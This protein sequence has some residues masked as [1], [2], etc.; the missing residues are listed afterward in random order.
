LVEAAEKK[1][2]AGREK[3]NRGMRRGAAKCGDEGEEES[4]GG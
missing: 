2:D 1:A 4:V 3:E